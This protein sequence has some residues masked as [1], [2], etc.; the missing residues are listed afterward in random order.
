[1]SPN[2]SQAGPS[3]PQYLAIFSAF[4]RILLGP[5]TMFLQVQ[6]LNVNW[7]KLPALVRQ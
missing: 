2:I 7:L 5:E 1:M 3:V 6:C 4:F